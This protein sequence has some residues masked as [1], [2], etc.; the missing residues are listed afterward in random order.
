MS[1]LQNFVF[2]L[3]KPFSSKFTFATV[4]L[5]FFCLRTFPL[6]DIQCNKQAFRGGRLSLFNGKR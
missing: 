1:H 4:A 6:Y 5:K 3:Q 2:V